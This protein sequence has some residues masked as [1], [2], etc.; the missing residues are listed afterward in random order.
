MKQEK[1]TSHFTTISQQLYDLSEQ[2]QTNG[3]STA[4]CFKVICQ[5]LFG[6]TEEDLLELQPILLPVCGSRNQFHGLTANPVFIH[7]YDEATHNTA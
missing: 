5:D 4:S 2:L 6:R 7:L 1:D 3:E